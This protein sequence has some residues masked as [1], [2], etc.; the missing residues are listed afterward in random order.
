[1]RSNELDLIF[2]PG[3][4]GSDP[5]H[6]QRR[7]AGKLATARFVEQSDWDHPELS[8][9]TAAIAAAA[10]S[11]TRPIVFVAHSLGVASLL[12]ALSAL[13]GADIRGAFLVAPPCDA[14]L[15]PIH[16]AAFACEAFGPLPFGAD[17]AAS[18]D[19]AY[20][21]YDR[22]QAMARQWGATLIDAGLAGH[23]NV[24]SGHGPWPE[25]L[26]R[27]AKFLGALK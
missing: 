26:L 5:D 8:A 14:G 11:A 12:H 9:W 13:D 17:L 21:P 22:A 6:W 27:L 3:L 2:I 1:M 19:D 25:G 10:H 15:A 18:R 24:A 23:L 16:C 7:W 20:C 4:G